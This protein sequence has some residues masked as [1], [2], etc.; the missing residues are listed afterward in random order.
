MMGLALTVIVSKDPDDVG[1]HHVTLDVSGC[2]KKL[3]PEDIVNKEKRTN[4]LTVSRGHQKER[5][6]E[7]VL[8]KQQ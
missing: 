7:R 6:Q 1:L 4:V 8:L 2:G 5:D 3:H